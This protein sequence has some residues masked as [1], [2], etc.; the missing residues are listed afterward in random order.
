MD[1]LH[2]VDLDWLCLGAEFAAGLLILSLA[3]RPGSK[4]AKGSAAQVAAVVDWEP[5]QVAHARA[6]TG[7]G[8]SLSLRGSP[9][10][11]Q[12][13][14]DLLASLPN[15]SR[16]R[17][18]GTLNANGMDRLIREW[19]C[20]S[21]MEVYPSCYAKLSLSNAEQ[22][23]EQHGAACIEHAV[24]AVSVLLTE[25]LG[26]SASISRYQPHSFLLHCF[27]KPL[28]ECQDSLS[29]ICEQIAAPEFFSF[30][31]EAIPLESE[32][33]YWYCKRSVEPDELLQLLSEFGE[34]N[35]SAQ[36]E[37]PVEAPAPEPEVTPEPEKPFSIDALAQ[38]PCPWDD[39][40]EEPAEP[41]ATKTDDA[42][43]DEIKENEPHPQ[44]IE[45]AAPTETLEG[46]AS[47]DQIDELLAQLNSDVV[48]E[49]VLEEAS[50][51]EPIQPVPSEFDES[52]SIFGPEDE[53]SDDSRVAPTTENLEESLSDK[54][55]SAPKLEMPEPVTE[56][57]SARSIYTDDIEESILK[58][59]LASLFA[60]V[61][62][63]AM[64]DFGYDGKQ[65]TKSG[66][67]KPS[68]PP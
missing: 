63:S 31:E 12:R 19:S 37:A 59:D 25:S 18:T 13:L 23:M 22:L 11:K 66:P 54:Q 8:R 20:E 60:A 32:M 41:V 65:S 67:D 1:F 40:P 52:T 17:L 6:V 14:R 51:E 33:S 58:D 47:T 35:V 68:P 64:G 53:E 62:S 27:G 16:D 55:P 2:D 45:E 26:D 44:V 36:E 57:P 10:D 28:S 56:M 48:P 50:E 46:F 38:F 9:T 39:P 3:W 30:H 7:S 24:Q 49:P 15:A 34:E 4:S 29:A 5:L 61:R 43:T 42:V 21:E